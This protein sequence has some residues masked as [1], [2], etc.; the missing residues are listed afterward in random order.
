[1]PED[2]LILNSTQTQ[3]GAGTYVYPQDNSAED[4]Y[5]KGAEMQ[6]RRKVQ[7]YQERKDQADSILK[8]MD[9]DKT[10]IRPAD[11]Q[12]ITDYAHENLWKYAYDNPKSL[13]PS[14]GDKESMSQAAQIKENESQANYLANKSKLVKAQ[15]DI[16]KKDFIDHG[17]AEGL[18][19]LDKWY[20]EPDINKIGDFQYVPQLDYN[21]KYVYDQITSGLKPEITTGKAEFL[22]GGKVNNPEITRWSDKNWALINDRFNS[23]WNVDST[24]GGKYKEGI[25]THFLNSFHEL[26]DAEKKKWGTPEEYGRY[27]QL[28]EQQVSSKPNVD[29][30]SYPP[31]GDKPKLTVDYES[32]IP[33]NF[34]TEAGKIQTANS[35]GGYHISKNS[36]APANILI[37]A[38]QQAYDAKNGTQATIEDIGA[39][40]WNVDVVDVQDW[41]VNPQN[42]QLIPAQNVNS[43]NKDKYEQKRFALVNRSYQG[44]SGQV[45]KTYLIPYDEN[46][47]QPLENAG[48]KLN[49]AKQEKTIVRTGMKDGKKVIQYSDGTIEYAK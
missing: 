25:Q 23:G 6:Y 32:N 38:P 40:S 43:G 33:I 44:T 27:I 35:I 15:Y 10:G 4:S 21:Q 1:M 16:Y 46:I 18:Q 37:G 36:N 29:A 3:P 9:F 31:Q 30:V 22:A 19:A 47:S 2:F 45:N 7:A 26:G 17:D 48:I 28:G 12:P 49:D 14:F 13:A 24:F 42:K 41:Y 20:A 8:M 5:W 34:K 39:N 11:L